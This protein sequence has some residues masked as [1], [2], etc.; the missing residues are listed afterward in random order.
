MATTIAWKWTRAGLTSNYH[1]K[2][3]DEHVREERG[4]GPHVSKAP[5]WW[6]KDVE[7]FMKS[8]KSI[9][10][11]FSRNW[12]LL[13]LLIKFWSW[14]DTS[15]STGFFNM[16]FHCGPPDVVRQGRSASGTLVCG[17]TNMERM[18]VEE[19]KTM[20]Q[21][22]P[23]KVVLEGVRNRAPPALK[24]TSPQERQMWP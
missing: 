11:E 5:C 17:H 18:N 2:I 14:I 8:M 21:W 24:G 13:Q 12:R 7:S 6:H 22:T 9:Y 16:I 3:K 15:A 19:P 23:S 4:G 1:N 20:P 10:A